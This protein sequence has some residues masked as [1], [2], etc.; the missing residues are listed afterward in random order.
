MRKSKPKVKE[1]QK[2]RTSITSGGSFSTKPNFDQTIRPD[3]NRPV[4]PGPAHRGDRRDT[5][6]SYTGNRRTSA[7]H[8]NPKSGRGHSVGK[9]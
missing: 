3:Q 2:G 1:S 5:N 4:G 7:N 6:P 9:K 8:T